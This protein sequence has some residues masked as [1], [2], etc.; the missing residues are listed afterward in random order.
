MKN[1]TNQSKIIFIQ[2]H[3]QF[4]Y[5]YVVPPVDSCGRRLR[6]ERR[7]FC[8]SA[9]IPERR[10]GNDRRNGKDRRNGRGTKRENK[11]VSG[12]RI[13]AGAPENQDCKL[14]KAVSWRPG[15][16]WPLARYLDFLVTAHYKYH[17]I[18]LYLFQPVFHA[19]KIPDCNFR[20]F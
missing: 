1:P 13:E 15:I 5:T 4:K 3:G 17:T 8:Y 20:H 14:W 6:I 19:N 11:K 10:S 9:F 16:I 12:A 18:F 7:Q 2:I